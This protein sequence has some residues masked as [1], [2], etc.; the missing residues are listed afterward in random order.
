MNSSG[1][2]RVLRATGGARVN[3]LG[4]TRSS[5]YIGAVK[6]KWSE[7]FGRISP[8]LF[9]FL[10]HASLMHFECAYPCIGCAGLSYCGNRQKFE[11]K[12]LKCEQ[13]GLSLA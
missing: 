7:N 12:L 4:L 10:R 5:H 3:E 2:A 8:W 11:Y 9:T 13:S 1:G 6:T